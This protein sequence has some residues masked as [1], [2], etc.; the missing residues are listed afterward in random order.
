MEFINERPN[1]RG[2]K[3]IML[4][5]V[6]AVLATAAVIIAA[7]SD[8][9]QAVSPGSAFSVFKAPQNAA[10]IPS[11]D[12]AGLRGDLSNARLATSDASGGKAYVVPDGTDLC[13][14]VA[15]GGGASE[16]CASTE[17]AESGELNSLSVCSPG[18]PGG[19]ARVAIVV[20]DGVSAAELSG[21]GESKTVP[22]TGNVLLYSN[23]FGSLPDTVSWTLKG[24]TITVAAPQV[25]AE[26]QTARCASAA[27]RAADSVPPKS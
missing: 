1:H 4:V 22:V 14:V 2:R 12:R 13:V 11:V 10:D 18:L 8:S 20:P 16:G 6:L 23:K 27:D 25:P 7:H 26:I 9:A 5:A 3:T 15:A 24:E 21:D 19:Q 17:L